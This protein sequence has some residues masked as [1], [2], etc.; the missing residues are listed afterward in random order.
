MGWLTLPQIPQDEGMV[1]DGGEGHPLPGILLQQAADEVLGILG[2][3]AGEAEVDAG[4][5]TVRGRMSLGL[6]G[7]S[8]D[9]ELVQEDAEG[10]DVDH[11]VVLPP[12]D[13][14]GGE[15]VEGAAQGVA[16]GGRGVDRPAEVGDLDLALRPDEEVLRLDV[17]VDDVLRVAVGQGLAEVGDVPG[18]GALGEPAAVGQ[19]LVQLAS[20]TVL[21]DE[22]DALL[23]EEVAEHPEDVAVAQVGLDLDLAAELML[24]AGLEELGLLQHLEGDDVLGPLLPGQV[25]G[26]ELAPAEGLADLE[27]VEGPLP[28]GPGAL[29][30]GIQGISFGCGG[31]GGSGGGIERN[32]VLR[33]TGTARGQR[34]FQT[35]TAGRSLVGI[36]DRRRR[37]RRG[38]AA[39]V[40][41]VQ[42]RAGRMHDGT[43]GL[44]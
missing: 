17:A 28:A 30:L 2:D 3:A 23:V 8:A 4:D 33:P 16:A 24:D 14:L 42:R 36:A 22:V 40:L 18:R 35:C 29:G 38:V 7:R 20:G 19:F 11:L 9:E 12:L 44:F 34:P 31:G 43:D 5:A 6:E 32:S 25:D 10:P 15:V 13:H 1:R 27:V 21:E 41:L 37:R 39:R 26:A